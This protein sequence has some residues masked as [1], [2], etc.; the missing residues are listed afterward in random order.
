MRTIL[1]RWKEQT[2]HYAVVNVPDDFDPETHAED[3]MDDAVL[4]LKQDT[5]WSGTRG[6]YYVAETRDYDPSAEELL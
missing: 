3:E 2:E 6:S 5:Y 1:L 4:E